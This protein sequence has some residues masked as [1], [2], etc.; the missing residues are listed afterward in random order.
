[1][2]EHL[3]LFSGSPILTLRLMNTPAAITDISNSNCWVYNIISYFLCKFSMM[4]VML[5]G[6]RKF[7]IIKSWSPILSSI[8]DNEGII[9]IRIGISAWWI[10]WIMIISETIVILIGQRKVIDKVHLIGIRFNV[11]WIKVN[12]HC[13]TNKVIVKSRSLIE[14]GNFL[15]GLVFLGNLNGRFTI[16]L[17]NYF[18]FSWTVLRIVQE[19]RRYIS[20][21]F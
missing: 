20:K 4:R 12:L 16:I 1:M 3:W 18:V 9:V 15:R 2:L 19:I 17:T 7:K 14:L 21:I 11:S 10:N 5:K 13:I 8:G 6:G